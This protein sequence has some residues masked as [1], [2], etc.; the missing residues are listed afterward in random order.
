MPRFALRRRPRPRPVR[1]DR[2]LSG[3]RRRRRAAI[4]RHRPAQRV[5]LQKVT[6]TF[7]AVREAPEHG[8]RH[9]RRADDQRRAVVLA[10]RAARLRQLLHWLQRLARI[11]AKL[12]GRQRE[13]RDAPHLRAHGGRPQLRL[14]LASSP[15]SIP[16]RSD[17]RPAAGPRA[18]R[19]PARGDAAA[20]C[21]RGARSAARPRARA[22]ERERRLLIQAVEERKA[23]RNAELAG[24][25]A[26]Q[27]RRRAGRRPDRAGSRAR[28][29]DRAA[30]GRA[31]RRRAGGSTRILLE[32]PNVTLPDVPAGGEEHNVIVRE[33]GRAA[34]RRRASG[35]TGR[36][37]P[38]TACSIS[39]ARRR[40]AAPASP[41]SAAAARGSCARSS[42]S[43]S[44]RT[45]ASTATRKSGRPRS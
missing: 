33:L 16:E 31:R 40:S 5:G 19:R 8:L 9:A 37:P 24:S 23:A 27:A 35:R 25:R 30:R 22:L 44:T 18:P 42:T 43:S 39:S 38:S 28:R 7:E 4:A 11:Y 45:R 32:V 12:D 10:V 29:G 14:P 1:H 3:A 15:D 20:R 34:R 13:R 26:P 21:A 17:A 36:S 41:S 6:G 2:R